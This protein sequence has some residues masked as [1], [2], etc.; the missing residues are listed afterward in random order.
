MQYKLFNFNH[1][2]SKQRQT[3]ALICWVLYM[4]VCV[5]VWAIK[6]NF[7]LW[8]TEILSK[9]PA[10]CIQSNACVVGI[11]MSPFPGHHAAPLSTLQFHTS[12]PQNYIYL[13]NN[14]AFIYSVFTTVSQNIFFSPNKLMRYQ[15]STARLLHSEADWQVV[16]HHS[17]EYA[18]HLSRPPTLFTL[19][20]SDLF[21]I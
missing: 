10:V 15:E 9:I 11:K 5:T 1:L 2:T 12:S 8:N 4:L 13:C 16:R 18:S 14:Y 3:I 7:L 21:R 17:W 19:I 20:F 6:Y